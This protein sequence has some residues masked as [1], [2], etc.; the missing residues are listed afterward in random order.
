MLKLFQGPVIRRASVYAHVV[1]ESIMPMRYLPE[2]IAKFDEW[3]GAYPLLVFPVRIFDRGHLS[4]M[5]TPRPSE[6]GDHGYDGGMGGGGPNGGGLGRANSGLWVDLGAYGVPR[7][8]KAGIEWDAKG[9]IRE[10]EHWTRDVGGFQ[11]LYTDIACTPAEL[12]QMFNLELLDKARE[13]LHAADAFP[14]VYQKVFPEAGIWDLSAEL[15]AEAK[16]NGKLANGK[17]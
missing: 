11:A 7:N 9:S 15:A 12:R 16:L 3:F 8:V 1:Q 2:G 14:D 13:K 6:C 10:M 4:G 17:H 5:L